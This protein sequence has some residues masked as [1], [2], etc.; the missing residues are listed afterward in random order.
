MNA[1]RNLDL[2]EV[3]NKLKLF[4]LNLQDY[5]MVSP[6]LA[7]VVI[8]MTGQAPVKEQV[9]ASVADLFKGLASPVTA[10]FRQ[11]TNTGSTSVLVGFVKA[12]SEVRSMTDVNKDKMKAMASNLL[13]DETDQSLWEIRKGSTGQYLVK[14][15][16]EDLSELANSLYARKVGMPTLANVADAEACSK[17]FAAF[18]DKNS[19]EV[20]HGYVIASEGGTTTILP[21]GEDEVKTIDSE[22]LV[23]VN[24]L[25]GED[26]KAIGL[27][28]A[29]A[30]M[31][32]N[33][34]VE[35]YKKAYSYSPDYIQSIIDM[36]DQHAFA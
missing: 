30:S 31:D 11:L 3:A 21:Y 29:T 12:S 4:T 19:E 22:Q 5:K 10:S 35:Y 34:M 1:Y 17:E 7:K 6:T 9:R 33:A 8:T 25:D 16:E 23:E 27:Q 24:N 36:I 14:Q 15:G 13:M 18:I 20:E 32:R 28:M 2:V 26:V